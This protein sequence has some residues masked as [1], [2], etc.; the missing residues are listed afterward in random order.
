MNIISDNIIIIILA[1][2]YDFFNNIIME[3]FL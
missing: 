3:I 2:L 1:N